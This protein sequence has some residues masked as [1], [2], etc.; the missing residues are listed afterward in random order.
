MKY[1]SLLFSSLFISFL[2]FGCS[3]DKPVQKFECSPAAK[4]DCFSKSNP[5]KGSCQKGSQ[6][7]SSAGKWGSCKGE[8]LP[9]TEFCDGKDNDCDGE[10]DEGFADKGKA[11][12][13]GKGICETK[14]GTYRCS[15]D[16]K[17]LVC[18]GVRP[19]KPL[20]EVCDGKDNDCDGLIDET[21]CLPDKVESFLETTG[22][23]DSINFH[24]QM[25]TGGLHSGTVGMPMQSTGVF[26]LRGEL[27]KKF[28]TWSIHAPSAMSPQKNGYF[29][30]AGGSRHRSF[31]L[32]SLPKLKR[33]SSLSLPSEFHGRA[34]FGGLKFSTNGNYLIYV[35]L[36]EK[37][38]RI[39]ETRAFIVVWETKSWKILFK[40]EQA[41][42]GS[43]WAHY[44]PQQVHI[45][46]DGRYLLVALKKGVAIYEYA[47]AGFVLRRIVPFEKNRK[48]AQVSILPGN[49]RFLISSYSSSG[50][51]SLFRTFLLDTGEE[52]RR[53][54]SIFKFSTIHFSPDGKYFFE[55]DH[56]PEGEVLKNY[57]LFYRLNFIYRHSTSLRSY[58]KSR[59]LPIG[60]SLRVATIG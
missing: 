35:G 52:E 50:D 54:F 24:Y 22:Y 57:R 47:S 19:G 2:L 48:V 5:L 9:S 58:L 12:S 42:H 21:C 29:V 28:P 20:D 60:R 25:L 34:T 51:K 38:P 4:R 33:L 3:P 30:V 45:T 15:D 27:V 44:V 8:I 18:A 14:G 17:K 41:Y 1:L 56:T 32:Y 49:K 6:L 23:H 43:L 11:C 31:G 36:E 55:F 16:R 26:D 37:E 10:I 40:V 46:I 7:C 39:K 53:F 13:V 59:K